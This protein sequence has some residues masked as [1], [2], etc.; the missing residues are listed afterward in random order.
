MNVTTNDLDTILQR[1]Q[2]AQQ[3]LLRQERS[4]RELDAALA[5]AYDNLSE[6]VEMMKGDK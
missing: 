5:E 6:L 1:L 4:L 2:A 3:E